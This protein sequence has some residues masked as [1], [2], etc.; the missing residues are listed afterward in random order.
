MATMP[1]S[2]R[3]P[4]RARLDRAGIA[5][6]GLCAA[7]CVSS[8]L[9]VSALGIGSEAL[10]PPALH[11]IGLLLAVIFAAAAIGW[12]ALQHRRT[13]PLVIALTGLGLMGGALMV[14]HGAGEAVLTVI[15]VALVSLGHVL[16][17]RPTQAQ[18]RA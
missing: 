7:H 12:G 11:E 1:P 16:N 9:V 4:L 10:F 15:G 6:S 5:L 2:I 18:A 17:L 13:G 3:S 14:P 8:I